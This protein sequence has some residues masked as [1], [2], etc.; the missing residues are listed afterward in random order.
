MLLIQLETHVFLPTLADSK[1][2]D[3]D[4]CKTILRR[5][6]EKLQNLNLGLLLDGPSL[7]GCLG[8][9]RINN[10]LAPTQSRHNPPPYIYIYVYSV[11]FLSPNF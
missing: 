9:R 6:E 2:A 11:F 7:G 5:R 10:V 3:S 1:T 4:N 8:A